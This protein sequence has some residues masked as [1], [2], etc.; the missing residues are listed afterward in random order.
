MSA[1]VVCN[2]ILTHACALFGRLREVCLAASVSHMSRVDPNAEP[3]TAF[4]SSE[5]TGS[6]LSPEAAKKFL[7]KREATNARCAEPLCPALPPGPA[8]TGT[9][10]H[11]RSARE[12]SSARDACLQ[13]SVAAGTTAGLIGAGVGFRAVQR[14]AAST[15]GGGAPAMRAFWVCFSFFLPYM[16]I[17]NVTRNRC[18]KSVRASLGDQK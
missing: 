17:S 3:A 14:H 13:Q 16:F 5:A 2:L 9:S 11:S 4:H 8:H 1:V 15:K 7:D 18:Q 12:Q 10:R 6:N